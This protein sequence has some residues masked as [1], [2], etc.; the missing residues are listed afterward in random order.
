MRRTDA[1]HLPR[2]PGRGYTQVG[3]GQLKLFQVAQV[4]DQVTD[5]AALVLYRAAAETWTENDRPSFAQ[6]IIDR[7][8]A[9]YREQCGPHAREFAPWPPL[10]PHP[11]RT[12][13]NLYPRYFTDQPTGTG[14]TPPSAN[15][16]GSEV[17]EQL[18]PAISALRVGQS[19][20]QWSGGVLRAVVGLA[21]D[22]QRGHQDRLVVDLTKG[23]LIMFGAA[24]T[25]RTSFLRT[26]AVSLASE[27]RVGQLHLHLIDVT[28][29]RDTSLSTLPHVGTCITD[30][31]DVLDRVNQFVQYL[32]DT[33]NQRQKQ[34]EQHPGSQ[35]E[36]AL[37]VL[38]D[39]LSQLFELLVEQPGALERDGIVTRM[40]GLFDAGPTMHIW[41]VA[42]EGEPDMRQERKLY[43]RFAQRMALRLSNLADYPT[44]IQTSVSDHVELPG[45]GY[46]NGPHRTP[47]S[48]QIAQLAAPGTLATVSEELQA[49]KG[50]AATLA[51]SPDQAPL[52]LKQTA[53]ATK[54]LMRTMLSERWGTLG[55]DLPTFLAMLTQEVQASAAQSR[56][57]R[58]EWLEACVG[59]RS[60]NRPADLAFDQRL[61]GVHAMI[62]GGTG[63]GKSELLRTLVLDLA[64]RYPPDVLSLALVDFKGGGSFEPFKDLP[65]C[66]ELVTNLDAA[67]VERFFI[68]LEAEITRRQELNKLSGCDHI[69]DFRRKRA[70]LGAAWSF[71]DEHYPHL[72]VIIDEYT[73]LIEKYPSSRDRL[74]SLTR[75]GRSLGISLFLAAQR[76]ASVTDEMDA[77]IKLRIC[78]RVEQTE[79]SRLLLR[80]PDA[81]LLPPETPNGRGYIHQ[82]GRTLDLVQVAYPSG[83]AEGERPDGDTSAPSAAFYTVVINQLQ[84][85]HTAFVP[86][87]W[88]EPLPTNFALDS[89]V[90]DG[91]QPTP[92]TLVPALAE[93]I[94]GTRTTW[95]F[96]AHTV[97]SLVLGFY[98][99]PDQRERRVLALD[100]DHFALFG[101]PRSGRTT[102]LRTLILSLA[103]THTPQAVQI[104]VVDCGG[105]NFA[106]LQ[107]LPHLGAIIGRND[108]DF[109]DRLTRLINVFEAELQRRQAQLGAS[110]FAT[111]R[112]AATSTP[113]PAMLVMIDG[114]AILKDR[115]E[116]FL[117][118]LT[119]LARQSARYG[120]VLALT[121][122]SMGDLLGTLRD[123]L[124][125]KLTLALEKVEDYKDLLGSSASA[126]AFTPGRG[127][128]ALDGQ[129]R[130]FQV[131]QPPAA[132]S[133]LI[134]ALRAAAPSTD[135]ALPIETLTSSYPFAALCDVLPTALPAAT[136]LIPLGLRDRDRLPVILDTD[137]DGQHVAFAGA[138]KSGRTTALRMV[139]VALAWHYPPELVR[140]VLVDPLRK[141]ASSPDTLA[142]LPHVYQH[143]LLE[144]PASLLSLLRE[145]A[146]RWQAS[147]GAQRLVVVIDNFDEF[148]DELYADRQI[149]EDERRSLLLLV[150]RASDYGITLVVS[151][152]L[153]TT[154]SHDLFKT[155]RDS[156]QG[157]G[158]RSEEAIG[159]FGGISRNEQRQQPQ[160]R[161]VQV[162]RKVRG[163]ALQIASVGT[164]Q[165]TDYAL[166]VTQIVA[167]YPA[168]LSADEPATPALSPVTALDPAAAAQLQLLQ[169]GL[170]QLI[171]ALIEE[172]QPLD[173][174]AIQQVLREY[175]ALSATPDAAQREQLLRQ[176]GLLTDPKWYKEGAAS[177]E[178]LGDH[179]RDGWTG[180]GERSFGKVLEILSTQLQP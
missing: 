130:M 111:Y 26:L 116:P 121:A 32:Y 55:C 93:W 10:L 148:T 137:A 125:R 87:P 77:N 110:N 59:L 31:A 166:L 37:V 79:T 49:L 68:V 72:F 9:L 76:T 153:R 99:A 118:R 43:R 117:L 20:L 65:H 63:S 113:L 92:T 57:H 114:A 147:S 138:P 172:T 19:P 94:Q 100:W 90:A 7:T 108:A 58:V 162:V 33:L 11:L 169:R 136:L 98:D 133:L 170:R 173:R 143:R 53:L 171:T 23:N 129:A 179:I 66:A 22:P 27:H 12:E 127:Y 13:Q 164:G 18:L 155:V 122:T 109:E 5:Q 167:R 88:P 105:S 82:G 51:K 97:P 156:A 180:K 39:G 95:P 38:I 64:L 56:H 120:I 115:Y 15:A 103:A 61:A 6:H 132:L 35:V 139:I 142:M 69:V 96:D 149:K 75:V 123:Q 24:S 81:A 50:I 45:R 163:A 160:G 124:G 48:F 2:Q 140:L 154:T 21:D 71:A 30:D 168:A 161:G 152:G 42:T 150:K 101:R 102:L 159:L 158:L 126:F 73:E 165:A 16:G 8:R 17:A 44:A 3:L 135:L 46:F 40:Q 151:F 177:R 178:L 4:D 14:G 107:G 41:F 29:Q 106:D 176:I 89:P 74:E 131:A 47:V 91:V 36:P 25:G 145:Q 28:G 104:Y 174:A 67:A 157:I 86:R 54:Y 34:Q 112:H 52:P 1:A 175:H 62:A 119:E 60:G 85:I 83:P 146:Q 128:L 84:A 78:L 70:D 141:L 134:A 80:R 144:E